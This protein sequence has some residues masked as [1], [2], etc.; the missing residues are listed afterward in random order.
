MAKSL[1]GCV[2]I[3][4]HREDE[5]YIQIHMGKLAEKPALDQAISDHPLNHTGEFKF[6]RIYETDQPGYLLTRLKQRFQDSYI[7]RNWYRL[8]TDTSKLMDS[9]VSQEV[10]NGNL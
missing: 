9:I 3:V 5:F 2:F 7:D 4:Q 10:L 1:K 6:F 8:S